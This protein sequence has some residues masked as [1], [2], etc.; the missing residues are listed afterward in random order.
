MTDIIKNRIEA[1]NA[2]HAYLNRVVPLLIADIQANGAKIKAN[3]DMLYAKDH[4]RLKAIYQTE[5]K[6]MR[7]WL[8]ISNV[9]KPTI[10]LRTSISYSKGEF[11]ADYYETTE[12]IMRDDAEINFT[13]RK[14]YDVE[15]M[16]DRHAEALRMLEQARNLESEARS[17]LYL[18]Q[19][20]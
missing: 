10:Y 18:T 15:E 4:E 8:S 2:T 3:G 13:P 1:I 7:T 20:R 17:T 12:Y 6:T 16:R 9:A 19:G 14:L 11:S 5:V